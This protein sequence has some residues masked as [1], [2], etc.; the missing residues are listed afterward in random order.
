MFGLSQTAVER[1]GEKP[2]IFRAFRAW[3]DARTEGVFGPEEK[4]LLQSLDS[5]FHLENL[6]RGTYQLTPVYESRL[7]ATVDSGS[8]SLVIK[9]PYKEQSLEFALRVDR[10]VL[11]GAITIG[12]DRIPFERKLNEG[13]Y[14]IVR[15]G[16]IVLADKYRKKL[17]VL[18]QRQNLRLRKGVSAV[19]IELASADGKPVPTELTVWA[20]GKPRL[21]G[22]R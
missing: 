3:E 20:W 16:N 12:L 5:K 22:K 17:M 18:R 1:S 11:S 9:N 19:Q 21:V 14:L 4:K 8:R 15:G 2:E 13:Q 7:T 6:G 10:P